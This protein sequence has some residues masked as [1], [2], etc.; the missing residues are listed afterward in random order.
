MILTLGVQRT[1]VGSIYGF[2]TRSRNSGLGYMLHI[3]VVG[4]SGLQYNF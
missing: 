1:N 3:W 2:S 4:P